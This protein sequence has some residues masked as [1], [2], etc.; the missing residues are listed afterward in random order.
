MSDSATV[1][2]SIDIDLEAPLTV[3]TGAAL[4][5]LA[6]L[7]G[8]YRVLVW[9]GGQGKTPVTDAAGPIAEAAKT[10]RQAAGLH[11]TVEPAANWIDPDVNT[12]AGKHE[13][14]LS[15][16]FGAQLCDALELIE[17]AQWFRDD[18][19]GWRLFPNDA[20]DSEPHYPDE[21]LLQLVPVTPEVQI[22]E[23]A[24]QLRDLSQGLA[25]LR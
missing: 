22:R 14:V 9:L 3:S 25:H 4:E 15:C 19:A 7:W 11:A 20:E 18:A 8:A 5:V 1:G 16:E 21:A 2:Q 17:T 12:P 24:R 13:M 23:V 6:A 10:F